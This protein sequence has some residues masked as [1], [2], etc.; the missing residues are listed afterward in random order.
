M[1]SLVALPAPDAHAAVI[2][3]PPLP[4][5]WC[6]YLLEC[7]GGVYYAGITNDLDARYQAHATGRGARFTRAFP[8]RR[9][10]DVCP[11][12]DRSAASKAEA[13]LKARP[14]R[15]KPATIRAMRAA[16]STASQANA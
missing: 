10:I 4:R 5:P 7:K 8:P 3:P 2:T 15:D 6:L 16:A 14:R 11:F 1:P 9:I 12:P 13:V